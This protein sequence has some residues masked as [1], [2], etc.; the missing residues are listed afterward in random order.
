[1]SDRNT[2]AGDLQ[3]GRSAGLGL[4]APPSS[5]S[6]HPAKHCGSS[7]LRGHTDP[8]PLKDGQ[9]PTPHP[10]APWSLG[11]E[12]ACLSDSH[13]RGKREGAVLVKE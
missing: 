8:R 7:C 12:G 2:P 4:S 3:P 11:G 10:P 6:L 5:P 13:R 1:M 9:L